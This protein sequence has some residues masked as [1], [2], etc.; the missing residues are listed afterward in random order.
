[1]VLEIRSSSLASLAVRLVDAALAGAFAGSAAGVALAA[2]FASGFDCAGDCADCATSGADM[3]SVPRMFGPLV[4]GAAGCAPMRPAEAGVTAGFAGSGCG[5]AGFAGV[6]SFALSARANALTPMP[7]VEVSGSA[8]LDFPAVPALDG[9]LGGAVAALFAAAAAAIS[10][11]ENTMV[12]RVL[13][14]LPGGR[15]LVP[16]DDGACA[17][18][19]TGSSWPM[20]VEPTRAG[21]ALVAADGITP[22][23]WAFATSI[24][25]RSFDSSASVGVG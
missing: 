11:A 9:A 10:D 12:L 8:G 18:F 1:M 19:T 24:A 17:L 4:S 2:G 5:C 20:V 14:S 3:M 6:A 22:A 15:E 21:F 23:A 7:I 25:R 13:G 16:A